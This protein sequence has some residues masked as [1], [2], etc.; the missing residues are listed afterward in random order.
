VLTAANIHDRFS[1]SLRREIPATLSFF[2]EEIGHFCHCDFKSLFFGEHPIGVSFVWFVG[3]VAVGMR[4]CKPESRI[5]SANS[6][7]RKARVRCGNSRIVMK[8]K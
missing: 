8:L 5:A 7:A 4:S 6:D 2:L 3:K 1:P